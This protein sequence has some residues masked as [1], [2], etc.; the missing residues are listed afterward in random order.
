MESQ[1]VVGCAEALPEIILL[2]HP[3]A[4]NALLG[5]LPDQHQGAGPAVSMA[6]HIA[7]RAHQAGDVDVVPAG[8]H[9]ID[10]VAVPVELLRT[11]GVGQAGL[12]LHRQTVH[13]GAH[14][15]QR[16]RAVLQHGHHAGAA[17][18]LGHIVA[19]CTQLLRQARRGF[20]LHHGEF[21]IAVKIVEQALEMTV[22]ILLH[23]I[24]QGVG[25]RGSG[26]CENRGQ[27]KGGRQ[28][29]GAADGSQH[30]ISSPAIRK[31]RSTK[32]A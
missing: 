5:G 32:V 27:R 16:A 20:L 24:G 22:V 6:R 14:H 18:T 15:Y 3:G 12:F 8:V 2:H 31:G 30:G 28:R 11:G 29:Q 25:L 19:R 9:H 4:A 1:R 23:R 7:R 10:L 26:K 21:R 17:D 13:I